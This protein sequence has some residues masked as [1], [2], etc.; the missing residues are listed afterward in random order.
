MPSELP[1]LPRTDRLPIPAI[2]A[3]VPDAARKVVVR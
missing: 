3:K 1:L 2:M